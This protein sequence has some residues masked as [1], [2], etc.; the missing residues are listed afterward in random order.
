M[1]PTYSAEADAFREKIQAFLAEHL[2]AD[3]EGIGA[4][5]G[6]AAYDFTNNEWRPLLAEQRYLAPSWPV[7][8]GGG[9]LTPLEQVILAEEF[10]RAGV[11]TGGTNDVFWDG[12]SVYVAAFDSIAA[13]LYKFT[14]VD[15]TRRYKREAGFPVDIP[16]GAGSE[17]VGIVKDTQGVLWC[18]TVVGYDVLVR[19]TLGVAASDQLEAERAHA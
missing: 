11:P 16:M 10:G 19:H 14:Y 3:W 9:G 6:E 8:Y 13:T 7:E 2:P 4:L 5:D 12:Q 18:G 1:D 15:S 17:T